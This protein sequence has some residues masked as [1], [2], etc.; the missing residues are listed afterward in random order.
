MISPLLFSE[1]GFLANLIRRCFYGSGECD[2]HGQLLPTTM[3][4]VPETKQNKGKRTVYNEALLLAYC[5]CGLMVSYLIWGVLQ[6]KIMTQEYVHLEGNQEV[7]LHFRESQFLVFA[8]RFLAFAIAGVYLHYYARSATPQQSAP[9]Y[10]FSISSIANILS[11]WFQYE[12]LKFVNFPTQV[13]AKSCKIIPVMVMGKIVSRTKYQFYE[14]LTAGLISLGM[15]LFMT[16][17]AEENKGSAVTTLTGVF[18]LCMYMTSDSFNSNWQG[19]LFKSYSM[20]P[21]EMMFGVNMFSCIFTFSSLFVQSGFMDSIEFSAKHPAFVYDCLLLSISAAVGQLFIFFTIS[22]FG[23]VVFTIIMTLRQAVAILLSCLIYKH[24]LSSMGILGI[25]V[26]FLAIFLRVYCNQRMRRLRRNRAPSQS[27]P[28]I[29]TDQSD[30][31]S[32]S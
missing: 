10:K 7:R 30:P 29:A 22:K 13:L 19:A 11:A 4:A 5:F 1:F 26:V 28:L 20:S 12:A 17:S 18:L 14:Y 25:L 9:L 2:A 8:N 27:V 3:G 6:E 16:G 32:K 23:P 24:S 31:P 15:V 21:V